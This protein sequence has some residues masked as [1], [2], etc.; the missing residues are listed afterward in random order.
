MRQ[1]KIALA[2]R[3]GELSTAILEL[4]K[5]V[6][7]QSH[8]DLTGI[9]GGITTLQESLY[10]PQQSLGARQNELAR[11]LEEYRGGNQVVRT[12]LAPKITQLTT[13]IM[14]L[15]KGM[16][17]VADLTGL[18]GAI[19]QLEGALYTPVQALAARQGEL[20]TLLEQFYASTGSVQG[21]VES[22]DYGSRLASDD[23]IQGSPRR[24]RL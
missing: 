24:Q 8:G 19:A 6:L 17:A 1:R 18:R 5:T 14:E 22:A 3:I 15:S 7:A 20:T 9:Q 13:Q 12:D 10:T 16:N 21:R 4:S 11:L 23:L 2:P